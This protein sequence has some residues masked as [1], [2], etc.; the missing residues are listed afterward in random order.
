MPAPKK[1]SSLIRLATPDDA[2]LFYD[3]TFRHMS[4]SGNND[5]IFHPVGDMKSWKKEEN[6]AAIKE[7]WGY[8]SSTE[9]KWERAWALFVDNQIVGSAN[10]R[11]NPLPAARHRATFAIGIEK[12]Y[13]NQGFGK[14]FMTR[15]I[16]W[17]KDQPFLDWLDLNAFLNNEKAIALYKSFEFKE[18]GTTV[19][20][21]RVKGQSIDDIH[22]CLKLR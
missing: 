16:G 18:I 3:H 17:A 22:M 12:Q 21:F 10:I 8:P 7:R 20:I 11:A 2:E 13:R 19:D 15:A 14:L 9:F 5:L 4:E 6:V 1:E